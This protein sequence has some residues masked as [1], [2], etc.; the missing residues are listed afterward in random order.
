MPRGNT[1]SSLLQL[2]SQK[3]LSQLCMNLDR[4]KDIQ[5][6]KPLG[7]KDSPQ[8]RIQSKQNPPGPSKRPAPDCTK[9]ITLESEIGKVIGIITADGE[10]LML[11]KLSFEIIL[12]HLICPALV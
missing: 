12:S 7:A 4:E 5:S 9:H 6:S 2:P 10:F 3:N 1:G 8:T 11:P